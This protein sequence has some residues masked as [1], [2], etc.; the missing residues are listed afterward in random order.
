MPNA[1]K[2]D[3]LKKLSIREVIERCL[4]QTSIPNDIV[5]TLCEVIRDLGIYLIEYKKEF[6]NLTELP[7]EGKIIYVIL[8]Y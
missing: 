4:N 5:T 7:P 8:N 6:K 3:I 1:T 2:L